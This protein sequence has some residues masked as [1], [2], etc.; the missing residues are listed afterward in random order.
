MKIRT[1]DNVVI[2][3]GKDKGRTGKVIRVEPA[4]QRVY[5]EGLNMI[6]RHQRPVP[7]RPNLQVGVIEREASIHISNVA[8]VDPKDHK[9]T[10]VGITREGG[11][12]KRVTRRT[13]T[14]LD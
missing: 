11:V 5:V 12:R 1:D 4:K 6:K 13:G 8:L 10:R 3:S 2:I 7:G 14:E 9:A